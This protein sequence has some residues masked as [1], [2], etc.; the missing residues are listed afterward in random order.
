VDTKS[1][2]YQGS[3]SQV[4]GAGSALEQLIEALPFAES[5]EDFASI[6]EGS[7]VEVVEDAI[8]VSGDQPRRKQLEAW[9]EVL[10]QP[11][12]EVEPQPIQIKVGDRLRLAKDLLKTTR[13]KVIQIL[14]WFGD[15][16]ETTWGAVALTEIELGTWQLM[17]SG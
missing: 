15:W 17:P 7:P 10:S 5:P 13:G 2:G 16:G 1:G 9:L 11:A 6:I 3:A 12:V 8:T 4:E 14:E